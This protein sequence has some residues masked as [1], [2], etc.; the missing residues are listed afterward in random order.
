MHTALA[1]SC[2]FPEADVSPGAL[3]RT[4]HTTQHPDLGLTSWYT[5]RA[6]DHTATRAAWQHTTP[7]AHASEL[8]VPHG[9]DRDLTVAELLQAGQRA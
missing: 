3:D 9:P 4:D 8:Q 2:V 1:C 5:V 6:G 7:P